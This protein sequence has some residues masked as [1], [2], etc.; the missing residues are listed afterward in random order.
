MAEIKIEKKKPIWPWV[1][2]A[3]IVLALILFFSFKDSD[4][5]AEIEADNSEV[6]EM[7]IEVESRT[8]A[9]EAIAN[10]SAYLAD[11][12][13]MGI[14]HVYS[15]GALHYLID[16]VEA[17]GNMLEVDIKADLDEARANA[18]EIKE[19]PYD[20]NH[21]DLIKK[22]GISIVRALTTMQEAKFP[23]LAKEVVNID[24]ALS[25][26]DKVELTLDQKDD[27]KNFFNLAE[28]LLVKMQ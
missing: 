2:L 19:E 4:N 8:I 15:S 26:I 9:A 23:D 22:S 20:I 1:L 5:R 10:Y 11:S 17:T 13:K 28:S 7:V 6:T 25:A 21:A 14:D 12:G 27:V 24:E 16:A 18:N 3:L